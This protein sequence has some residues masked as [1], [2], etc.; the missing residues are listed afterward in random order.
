MTLNIY[1]K[2]NELTN[3]E[4]NKLIELSLGRLLR[5]GSRKYQKGDMKQ[6]EKCRGLIVEGCYNPQGIM[7]AGK[8]ITY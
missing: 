4:L 2:I 1:N 5:I 3:E 8:N 6:Y 7:I